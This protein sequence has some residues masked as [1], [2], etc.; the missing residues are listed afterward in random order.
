ML[1]D[2]LLVNS[3]SFISR[4]DEAHR[5]CPCR[6]FQ[7]LCYAGLLFSFLSLGEGWSWTEIAYS[8]EPLVIRV[9]GPQMVNL[10]DQDNGQQLSIPTGT[11]LI[12]R[13]EAIP[14]TGFGWQIVENGFPQLHLEKDPVFEPKSQEEAGG[15]ED[16]VF[17]FRAEEP[18]MVNL[19]LHYR[20]PWEKDVLA[21]KTFRIQ[22]KVK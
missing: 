10:T 11:Q 17:R 4:Y 1:M 21:S 3:K 7:C 2:E 6:S 16:E 18:G 19:E 8:G 9:A 12:L 22:V 20:R 5:E 14:G 13:L 15:L